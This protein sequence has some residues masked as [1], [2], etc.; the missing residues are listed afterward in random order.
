MPRKLKLF[1]DWQLQKLMN[2]RIAAAYLNA[3]ILDSPERLPKALKRVAQ[4]R[5]MAKVAKESG[6]QRET[7]YRSLSEQGNPTWDTL[8]GVLSAVGLRIRFDLIESEETAPPSS[9][10]PSEQI[11]ARGIDIGNDG[12]E[13]D[14]DLMDAMIAGQRNRSNWGANSWNQL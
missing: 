12:M 10:A 2:P 9:N 1:S 4:A 5:Q 3:A 8:R 13:L 7:L 11:A 14:Q 6:V